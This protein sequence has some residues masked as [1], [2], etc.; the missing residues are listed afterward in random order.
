MLI[1]GLPSHLDF[2][3]DNAQSLALLRPHLERDPLISILLL[4]GTLAAAGAI[5]ALVGYVCAFP[6]LK[7][8]PDYLAL[9]MLSSA[10]ALRIIGSQ[11]DWIAGGVL[12]INTIDPFWW[13]GANSYY[14]SVL[15][16]IVL[17][18]L[19]YFIYFRM[20]NSPLGRLLKGIRENELTAKCVGKDVP[21]V[22]K[23]VMMFSFATLGIAGAL[24]AF[25][26]GA[27]IVQSYD[28]VNYSF[29]PW[30]MLIVGGS[31]NNIGVLA[32]AF[33]LVIMRRIMIASKQYFLFLPFDILWLEP[34][35]LAAMLMLILVFRPVGI[36][37]EK[38]S[39]V[40][41]D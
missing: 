40:K 27:V 13:L 23:K 8:P 34:I 19:I 25:N 33:L 6:A 10:E 5:S 18:G 22:K 14:G 20:C 26:I 37:P 38:R 24:D 28:R 7:L 29:W 3:N 4:I 11:T 36:F 39:R 16:T 9:F 1:Y 21:S 2:V 35:F 30:L 31:G 32:G 41:R 17:S 12:G 15:F